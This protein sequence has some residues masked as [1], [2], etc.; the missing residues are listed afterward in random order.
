MPDGHVTY[1][2]RRFLVQIE[3]GNPR[4]KKKHADA[5]VSLEAR[6]RAAVAEEART[7]AEVHMAIPWPE[8]DAFC[9]TL[10]IYG[11]G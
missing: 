7:G 6:I 10:P 5:F 8:W 9:E 3:R 4:P 1:G 2:A 11:G